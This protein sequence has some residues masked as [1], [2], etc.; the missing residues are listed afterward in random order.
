MLGMSEDLVLCEYFSGW[1]WQCRAWSYLLE[2]AAEAAYNTLSLNANEMCEYV[3]NSRT[4]DILNVYEEPCFTRACLTE[5]VA[6]LLIEKPCSEFSARA[7]RRSIPCEKESCE[8]VCRG[9]NNDAGI[10]G[11]PSFH[12]FLRNSPLMSGDQMFQE[13]SCMR[14]EAYDAMHATIMKGVSCSSPDDTGVAGG[15]EWLPSDFEQPVCG[16]LT[17]DACT[18]G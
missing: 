16:L 13:V 10:L 17:V 8:C 15:A 14:L 11:Y 7:C 3:L 9:E 18:L 4:G 5:R 6:C 12:S 2:D 1:V